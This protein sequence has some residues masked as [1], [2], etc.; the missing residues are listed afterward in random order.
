MWGRLV[1]SVS[2]RWEA[3]EREIV[4]CYRVWDLYLVR[5]PEDCTSCD[6]F[7]IQKAVKS[8]ARGK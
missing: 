2:W 7:M 8:K 6:T 4:S 1:R 3:G 5:L